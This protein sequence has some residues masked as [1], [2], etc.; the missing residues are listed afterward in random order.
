MRFGDRVWLA[1]DL[2]GFRDRSLVFV[3]REGEWLRFLP[4]SALEAAVWEC[5]ESLV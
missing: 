4:A 2:P 1:F 5:H 3:G